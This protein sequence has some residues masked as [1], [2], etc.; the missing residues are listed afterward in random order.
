MRETSCRGHE[1]REY[2]CFIRLT[3]AM[4][5][6][7]AEIYHRGTSTLRGQWTILRTERR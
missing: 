4:G 3:I 5:L 1:V 6:I 7:E 2:V